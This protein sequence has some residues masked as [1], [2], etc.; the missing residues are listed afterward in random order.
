MPE[1]KDI[2]QQAIQAT[3]LLDNKTEALNMKIP[4]EQFR[5]DPR[6]I[7]PK[8][9]AL[10]TEMNHRANA[11]ERRINF[12]LSKNLNPAVY[13]DRLLA[14]HKKLTD[15]RVGKAYAAYLETWK[16]QNNSVTPAFIRWVRDKK[17]M[18]LIAARR[19]A[20]RHEIECREHRTGKM[21]TQLTANALNSWDLRMTRFATRWKNELEAEAVKLEYRP[22]SETAILLRSENERPLN[23]PEG[24]EKV[25]ATEGAHSVEHKNEP[26]GAKESVAEVKR[27]INPVA[28]DFDQ[29]AGREM[30]LAHEKLREKGQRGSRDRPGTPDLPLKAFLAIVR[31]VDKAKA[32]GQAKFPLKKVL[33]KQAWAEIAQH[34]KAAG[35]SGSKLS[36]LAEAA[37]LPRFKRDIRHR[38]NRAEIFYREHVVQK[39]S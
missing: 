32:R 23:A 2:K 24:P 30:H 19:A 26:V 20:V 29:F 9:Q 1:L 25:Q 10:S 37:V 6:L 18:P 3:S 8:L 13:L 36:T 34:N 14:F 28:A 31:K 5:L 22:V 16:D 4:T 27:R 12:E 35:P 7:L 38:F 15:E 11:E 17:I 33:S 21:H 39:Q